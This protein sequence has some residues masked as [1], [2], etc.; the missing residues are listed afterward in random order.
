MSE[1]S[2]LVKRFLEYNPLTGE[3]KWRPSNNGRCGKSAG[4]IQS[5]KYVSIRIQGKAYLAHRLA[6]LITY[7]KMPKKDIDHIDRN[8]Q[9]NRIDNLR[10]VTAS[11]NSRSWRHGVHRNV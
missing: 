9:N 7:G 8:R 10:E 4:S 3:F 1:L 5:N 2:E 11:E 6:W